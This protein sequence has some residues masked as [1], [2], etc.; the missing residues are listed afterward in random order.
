MDTQ[1]KPGDV[2]CERLGGPLMR[3]T[4]AE[5]GKVRCVFTTS[6]GAKYR[7]FKSSDLVK[8]NPP[9]RSP[10]RVYFH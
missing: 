4:G 1:F 7:D 2:A 10:I 5:N 8:V 9:K 3:V 6:R